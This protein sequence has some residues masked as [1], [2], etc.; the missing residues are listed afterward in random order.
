MGEQKMALN[1]STSIREEDGA[2]RLP[3]P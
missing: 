3:T 1:Y 2:G